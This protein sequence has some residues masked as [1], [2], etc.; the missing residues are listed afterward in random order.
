MDT[1]QIQAAFGDVFDQ[2]L[3]FY[4]FADYMRDCEVFICATAGPH[5]GIRPEH[6]RYRFINCVRAT[7]TSALSPAI[8][9][10]SL[11][12][13]LVDYAQGRDLDGYVWG[14]GRYCTP[15]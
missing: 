11:E 6:L 2:A 5:T 13:R 15:G 8:W 9:K 4:G 10:R 7:V 14:S 12:E 3:L 1:P